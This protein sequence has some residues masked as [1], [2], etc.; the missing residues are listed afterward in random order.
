MP[1]R[2][3]AGA[4]LGC[5]DAAM[6]TLDLT[7]DELLTTTRAVRKRLDLTRPVPLELVRECL[8]I[9]IQAP[10]GSNSQGWQW[11]VVT[12]P[13]TRATIAGYYK[14]SF[15]RYRRAGRAAGNAYADPQRAATQERVG[16]SSDWLSE[17]YAEVPVFVI[18]CIHA[19]SLPEGNQ[20]GL[21][22]SVIP[23]AWSYMLAARARGLGTCWTTLHLKYEQ[24]V[25][26]L[27]GLPE[28]MRQAALIPTAYF[29]GETFKPA[30]RD[31]LDTVLHL[32]RWDGKDPGAT[33]HGQQ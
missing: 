10:T 30:R 33:P 26:E 29:T 2:G 23:A 9:A 6:A 17:H 20:A 15:D 27:L 13:D 12:D 19:T 18:P 14:R 21:W 22:G 25:A 8:E 31:P 7:P 1:R 11:V 5:D 28:G 32:D 3:V 24:E 4:H 16:D